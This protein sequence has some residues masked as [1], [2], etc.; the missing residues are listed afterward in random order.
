MKTRQIP[1]NEPD[2]GRTVDLV[3]STSTRAHDYHAGQVEIRPGVWA[4]EDRVPPEIL[5][6]Y[7]ERS[8]KSA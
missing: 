3:T 7:L 8:R 6:P 4:Y 1:A 2:E 5:L